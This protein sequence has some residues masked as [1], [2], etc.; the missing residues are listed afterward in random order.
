MQ[1]YIKSDTLDTT[2]YNISCCH[3]CWDE[4]RK[5]WWSLRQISSKDAAAESCPVADD[6]AVDICV[7]EDDDKVSG[8]ADDDE[9]AMKGVVVVVELSCMDDAAAADDE[10][11][12]VGMLLM[13]SLVGGM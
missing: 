6:D 9:S 13:L 1:I 12:R 4:M 7:K 2:N 3:F 10:D 8:T 11:S 5:T